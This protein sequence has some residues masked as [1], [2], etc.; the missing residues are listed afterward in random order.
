MMKPLSRLLLVCFAA[1]SAP[2][3]QFTKLYPD[4]SVGPESV[5]FGDVVKLYGL[6]KE[7]QVLNAGRAPLEVTKIELI[8]QVHEDEGS[9][10]VLEGAPVELEP[11]EA[12]AV[13]I[14]FTPLEYLTY[15]ADL[16][17]ESNDEVNP[18]ITIPIEGSGIVGSTPDIEIDP[19]SVV[20]ALPEPGVGSTSGQ[21]TIANNGD[22]PLTIL[23]VLQTG[24]DAFSLV[25]DPVGQDITERTE[26]LVVVEYHNP[27]PETVSGHTGLLTIESTDPD[28]PA[29]GVVLIG[30]DGGEGGYDFPVA[31]IDCNFPEI[32]PPDVIILDGRLSYD[33]KDP[34]GTSP[35]TYEWTLA[36]Q[37]EASDAN[38]DYPNDAAFEMGIDVVGSYEVQL[39]VTDSNGISSAPTSCALEALPAEELYVVLSWNKSQT[40]LDLHVVPEDSDTINCK[41][42]GCCDCFFRNQNPD[43]WITEGF[44][45]CVYALDD[46]DGYGPENV[47]VDDPDDREFHIRA[48]YWDDHAHSGDDKVTVKATIRVYVN[49]D[50]EPMHEETMDLE[51]NERWN[52]G[53][54]SFDEGVGTWNDGGGIDEEK[55]VRS[56]DS[57]CLP[58]SR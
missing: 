51:Y 52:V 49:R 48:H 34:D 47:N 22:G 30:G 39:V 58:P 11:D 13:V 2:D 27:N 37:P 15:S 45:E 32:N 50:P 46:K 29:L 21:F 1:C 24:P 56:Y 4:I 25:T 55:S 19:Q 35:L 54:V 12:L 26:K 36:G 20:F 42:F 43:I 14:S 41:Y 8:N 23:N 28:E 3:T 17:I 6:E 38:I 53:F 40:D 44:G 33:P 5:D 31:V 7:I 9:V 10:F 57:E 16:L 18:V